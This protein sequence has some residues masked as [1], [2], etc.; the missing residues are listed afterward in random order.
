M[1]AHS[2]IADFV[3]LSVEHADL[4]AGRLQKLHV[5]PAKKKRAKSIQDF[6][7]FC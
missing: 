6:G 1:F 7:R 4:A 3:E 2:P 5:Q